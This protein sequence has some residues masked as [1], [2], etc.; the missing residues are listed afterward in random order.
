MS[1]HCDVVEAGLRVMPKLFISLSLGKK[2]MVGK[3]QSFV[4]YL[5]AD[6]C[7]EFNGKISVEVT[8]KC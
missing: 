6:L 3:N 8:V 5:F 1:E 2:K 4:V 7:N